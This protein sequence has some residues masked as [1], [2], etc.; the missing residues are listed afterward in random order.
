[1]KNIIQTGLHF[2]NEKNVIE[3]A[4]NTCNIFGNSQSPIF[5]YYFFQPVLNY[6]KHNSRELH[7]PVFF[8]HKT[9][10]EFPPRLVRLYLGWKKIF[11]TREGW[12]ELIFST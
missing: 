6:T 9:V 8:C 11:S 4:Q 2:E 3:N 12:E 7:A 1:M 5:N 10:T